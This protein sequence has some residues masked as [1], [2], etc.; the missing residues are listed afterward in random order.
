MITEKEKLLIAVVLAYAAAVIIQA[1]QQYTILL[2]VIHITGITAM[3]VAG[4][5]LLVL[6][7]TI[8]HITQKK[9]WLRR[10]TKIGLGVIFINNL[11]NLLGTIFLK[12][13]LLTFV[14]T[15]DPLIASGGIL[16]LKYA[17]ATGGVYF[18]YRKS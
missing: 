15:H 4:V 10:T 6:A 3:L 13:E 18:V 5:E 14:Q 16:L 17:V 8:G 1:T 12:Q 2:G 9:A 11:A 7:V